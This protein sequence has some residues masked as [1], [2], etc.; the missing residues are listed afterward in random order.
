MLHGKVGGD[1]KHP[2]EQRQPAA[3]PGAPRLRAERPRQLA[4]ATLEGGLSGRR[5]A[6]GQGGSQP[7]GPTGQTHKAQCLPGD[8]GAGW[9]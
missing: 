6:P 9:S 1:C 4:A 2:T 8:D 5:E 7:L 3:G